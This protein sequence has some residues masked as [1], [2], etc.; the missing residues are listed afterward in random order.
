MRVNP[1]PTIPLVP[2]ALALL[3]VCS[4]NPAAFPCSLGNNGKDLKQRVCN[5]RQLERESDEQYNRDLGLACSATFFNE[6]CTADG[7]T[8]APDNCEALFVCAVPGLDPLLS[9][10]RL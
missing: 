7:C 8:L 3:S 6:C 9:L 10:N 1:L 4:N 2:I 5:P